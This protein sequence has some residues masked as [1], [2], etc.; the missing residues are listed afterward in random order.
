MPSITSKEIEGVAFDSG[1][2]SAYQELLGDGGSHEPVHRLLGYEEPIQTGHRQQL[3]CQLGANGMEYLDRS[4]DA[5]AMRQ[6]SWDQAAA[7]HLLLQV[8]SDPDVGFEW[9]DVG[10]IY[11]WVRDEDSVADRLND[12]WL[13]CQSH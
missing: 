3:V 5:V 4:P 2:A 11:Y 9:G 13:V 10:R 1:E 12:T 7:W 8:D 6:Q